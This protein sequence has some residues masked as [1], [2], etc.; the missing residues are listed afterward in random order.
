MNTEE[1]YYTILGV[2][3]TASVDE[4]KEAFRKLAIQHHPDKNPGQEEVCSQ[5]FI[6][7][8]KAY[9]ILSDDQE[10]RHY[11]KSRDSRSLSKEVI[12]MVDPLRYRT[13]KVFSGFDD[14]K[15]GMFLYVI[16]KFTN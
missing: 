12:F 16:K 13:V 6:R 7:I 1:C 3:W 15:T 2:T 9:E 10:K 8:R 14:T 5:M 4:I 11:D